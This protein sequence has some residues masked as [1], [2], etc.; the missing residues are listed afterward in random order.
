M[1]R[2]DCDDEC[3]H[4]HDR[5]TDVSVISDVLAAE[6]CLASDTE[7]PSDDEPTAL[8]EFDWREATGG[9]TA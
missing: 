3:H 2:H 1:Q 5:I 4:D 7:P 9:P 8:T 6:M